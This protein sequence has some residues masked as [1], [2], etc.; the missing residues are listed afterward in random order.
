VKQ[1]AEAAAP[2]EGKMNGAGRAAFDQFKAHS[3]EIAAELNSALA[4]VLAGVG[5]M[6]TSFQTGV[7][8]MADQTRQAD[9]SAN[10]DAARFSS[11]K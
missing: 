8:D 9:A 11:S 1:L 4:A 3:D 6:N 7:Q 10:Y 5:G 2:L